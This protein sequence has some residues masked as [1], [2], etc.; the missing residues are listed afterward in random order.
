MRDALPALGFLL[1]LVVAPFF[2]TVGMAWSILHITD[3]GLLVGGGEI[4][5]VSATDETK[6]KMVICSYFTAAGFVE[7]AVDHKKYGYR[8]QRNCPWRINISA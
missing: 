5:T 6:E 7:R 3:T 8:G 4:K 1:A 2:I